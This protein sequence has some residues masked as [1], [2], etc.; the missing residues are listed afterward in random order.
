MGLPMY[1]GA[2]GLHFEDDRAIHVEGTARNLTIKN[3]SV[4]CPRCGGR[5]RAQEGTFNVTSGKWTLLREALAGATH[6]ELE[7]ILATLRAA[8]ARGATREQIAAEVAVQSPQLA[9][10]GQWMLSM[11]GGTSAQWLGVLIAIISVLITLRPSPTPPPQAPTVVNVVVDSHVTD[12]EIDE[13]VRRAMEESERRAAASLH[14]P[15]EQSRRR[16]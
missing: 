1:C 13:A 9:G 4:A 14:A 3:V 8:Q 12:D 6:T 2:C 15:P 16:R 7:G 10:L 11:Q 5:A